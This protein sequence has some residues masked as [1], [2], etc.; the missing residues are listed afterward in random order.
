[1]CL[2]Q[3]LFYFSLLIRSFSVEHKTVVNTLLLQKEDTY[4]YYCQLIV[5]VCAL[6]MF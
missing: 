3:K 6:S 5:E 1:M 4:L 2:P